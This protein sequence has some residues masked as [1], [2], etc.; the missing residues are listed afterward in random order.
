MHCFCFYFFFSF[1]NFLFYN[2]HQSPMTSHHHFPLILIHLI[3]NLHLHLHFITDYYYLH[4]HHHHHYQNFFVF[5]FD[6]FSKFSFFES[7]EIAHWFSSISF[8]FPPIF[9]S[10]FL[11]PLFRITYQKFPYLLAK[12]LF[13]FLFA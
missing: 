11:H 6:C 5:F 13:F 10:R 4:H 9:P 1:S 7:F 2:C 8:S 12:Q 3:Q